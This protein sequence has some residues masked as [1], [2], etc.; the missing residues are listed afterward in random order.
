MRI[1]ITGGAGFIGSH[2]CD[3]LIASGHSVTVMDDFSTGRHENIAH[4]E[5]H[6]LFTIVCADIAD[7]GI[8]RD[9]VAGADRVYH[10]ASAVGVRLI[11]EQPVR[12]IETIVHGTSV[13]MKA[14][15]RY[16]KPVLITSTS[17]VYGKSNKV[18]FAEDDDLVIGPSYRRRWGYACSKA[19]DEFL[20]MAYWHH[21]RMPVVIAR[22]FNTVGPR[23]TGQYGMVLPR[24]VQQALKEEP[25]T[26][27]GDGSQTR[28]FCH[29]KDVVQALVKLMELPEA[30]GQV[31]NI[32]NNEEVSI[33]E[34]AERVVRATGSRSP[35]KYV[36][37]EEAYGADFEDMRR[38]VPDL[39]KIRKAIGYQPRY[40]LDDII[41]DIV[42][43]YS[44]KLSLTVRSE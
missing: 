15:S 39:S 3:I 34:L 30:R 42:A 8:V 35:I 23:Q 12:T 41:R 16:R 20:A 17:E 14:C 32:G 9:C 24:F 29:V 38:R 13:I 22:L 40:S 33:R 27:Y 25:L 37:F 18:P 1:L 19:L 2:L 11:V 4:L 6:P 31:F 26:V 36:P 44:Q 21:S 28:C 5:G 7:E 43:Y 10:L